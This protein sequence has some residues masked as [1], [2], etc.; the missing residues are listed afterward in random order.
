[1]SIQ[2]EFDKALKKFEQDFE[3]GTVSKDQFVTFPNPA[4]FDLDTLASVEDPR[5]V[6]MWEVVS[7]PMTA[8]L[9]GELLTA[10]TMARAAERARTKA[11]QRA[12]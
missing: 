2:E 6:P 4:D 10:Q 12:R 11:K 8:K 7:V 3:K 9:R 1:M 5:E